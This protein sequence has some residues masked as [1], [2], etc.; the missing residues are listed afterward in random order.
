MPS[1]P[2]GEA[3]CFDSNKC[4]SSGKF[5]DGH[6]DCPDQSDE[7][8]C[9][10]SNSVSFGA[11]AGDGGSPRSSPNLKNAVKKDPAS[12]GLKLCNGHG[13]CVT[14]GKATRCRCLDGFR[15]EFCQQAETQSHVGVILGVLG[16]MAALIAA[17]FI[18]AKRRELMSFRGRSTDK[19]N[20][21]ADMGLPDENQDSDSE[22]LES[23]ADVTNS[24]PAVKSVAPS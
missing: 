9:L 23:S 4:I 13:S 21:M 7:Q 11:K 15:G 22:E 8:D 17:A 20:L 3:S 5:C 6:V 18:F 19:E 2:S 14:E 10:D 12:C 16:L 24:P 1:C